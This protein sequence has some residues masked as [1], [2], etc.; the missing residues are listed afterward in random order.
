MKTVVAEVRNERLT[1]GLDLED[2][3][4][5]YCVRAPFLNRR[6]TSQGPWAGGLTKGRA[7]GLIF[8]SEE[9]QNPLSAVAISKV[10]ESQS[11]Y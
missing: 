9:P 6:R 2:K 10:L 8:A 3:S 7:A 5:A 11:E 4:S 1:V